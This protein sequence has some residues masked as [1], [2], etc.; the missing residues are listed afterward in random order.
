MECRELG[1]VVVHNHEYMLESL[2]QLLK[3]AD[4]SP[5]PSEILTN[6]SGGGLDIEYTVKFFQVI[7]YYVARVQNCGARGG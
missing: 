4:A 6:F 5:L 1:G 2:G 3:C 7:L